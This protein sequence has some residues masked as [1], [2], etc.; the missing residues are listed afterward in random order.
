METPAQREAKQVHDLARSVAEHLDGWRYDAE[1]GRDR[2][3]SSLLWCA[4]LTDGER[5]IVVD[6]CHYGS[7]AGTVEFRAELPRRTKRGKWIEIGVETPS[8]RCNRS[9]DPKAIAKDVNRRLLPGLAEAHDKAVAAVA[10]HDAYDAQEDATRAKL[11]SSPH[12]GTGSR[13][14]TLYFHNSKIEACGDATLEGGGT[15]RIKLSRL[16]AEQVIAILDL[17]VDTSKQ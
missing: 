3:D 2:D 4:Y 9:R 12:F 5:S 16:T 11:T 7:K 14:N 10:Q 6:M 15:C 8:I 17:V 1:R 13:D